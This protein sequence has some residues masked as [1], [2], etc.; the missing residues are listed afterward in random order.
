MTDDVLQAIFSSDQDMYPAPLT[1]LHLQSWV[2]ASPELSRVFYLSGSSISQGA[3]NPDLA[4]AIIVLPLKEES[5]RDLLS[6]RLQETD[7]DASTMFAPAE[8]QACPV[9]LHVFHIERL[10]SQVKGFANASLKYAQQT[11]EAKGWDVLGC[12]G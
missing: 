4:G 11:A 10:S 8:G 12:S 6:G 7:I 9:G 2:D 3:G 5:W 1:Y